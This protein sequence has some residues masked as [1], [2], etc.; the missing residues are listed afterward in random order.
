MADNPLKNNFT[1]YCKKYCEIHKYVVYCTCNCKNIA[2]GAKMRFVNIRELSK[3]P[4]KYLKSANE[5]GD[6]IITRNGKPFAVISKIDES[7]LEDYVLAKHF[8]LEKEFKHALEE[9]ER[10]D[11]LNAHELLKQVEGESPNEI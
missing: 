7:E 2:N 3:S 1:Y 6:I 5:K 10:D 8:D 9:F 11:T 4:S